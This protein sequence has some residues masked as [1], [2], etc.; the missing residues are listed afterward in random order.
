[1]SVSNETKFQG[2]LRCEECLKCQGNAADLFCEACGTF[3]CTACDFFVH[4]T[5]GL[6]T[7]IREKLDRI[8]KKCTVLC[9]AR[10]TVAIQCDQCMMDFCFECDEQWHAKGKRKDH[11]R[12]SMIQ[13]AKDSKKDSSSCFL[14][15]N[16]REE[17]MVR[18]RTFAFIITS[19]STLKQI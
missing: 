19:R 5:Q 18:R 17:L 8:A 4:S 7:H 2:D 13:S 14:L 16:D 1:M 11:H 15:I 9:C 3:L 6:K 12:T 10:N